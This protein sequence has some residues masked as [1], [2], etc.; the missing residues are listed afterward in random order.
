MAVVI[1]LLIILALVLFLIAP[2]G[3]RRR[4]EKWKGTAFAHRGLHGG[5]VCE[6]TLPA[7]DK[8]CAA[9]FGSE[10]DVQLSAD[11]EV[12][13]FHDDTLERLTGDKRR[14]DEVKLSELKRMKLPGGGNIP[15][16]SEMLKTVSGRTPL[17]VELKNGK[18]N[19]ELCEKTL[20]KLREYEGEYIIESFN[21]LILMW[22]RKN[23]PEIIRGQ[24]VSPKS[25]YQP[26]FKNTVAFVLSN[27]CLNFLGRPDFIAYD[28]N[29]EKFISP[30]IQRTLFKTPMAVWTI[31][32]PQRHHEALDMGEMPIFEGFMPENTKEG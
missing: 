24:L 5:S 15:T 29:A 30:K 31:K 21:P 25:G 14:V 26:Q 22:F 27:L 20:K 9:G 28:G 6:N 4:A 11:G 1:V 18:R 16:F 7:F 23:A 2:S 8:A 17:L 10:L 19:D 12:V 13:V 3:K 32:D